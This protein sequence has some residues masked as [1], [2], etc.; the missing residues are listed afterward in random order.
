LFILPNKSIV[1]DT[2]GMR[3]IGMIDDRAGIEL[4]YQGIES[5]SE[6]CKFN[7]CTHLDE[8][9]CAVLSALEEGTL[10]VGIYDNYQKLQ[11]EQ[12]HF[13]STV[14]EKRRKSKVQG[15]LYKAVQQARRK[16]K[17]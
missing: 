7:N 9:G 2:P 11:R 3:E 6:L 13:S 17:Y 1:I 12:A 4:T 16:N 10:A 5:L 14:A 15:K 8:A